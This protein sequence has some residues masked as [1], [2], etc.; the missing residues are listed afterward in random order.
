ETVNNQK[1]KSV[2]ANPGGK[3]LA[4]SG[5][6]ATNTV[7]AAANATA[8]GSNFTASAGD[9]TVL[10]TNSATLT[11]S[12]VNSSSTSLEKTVVTKTKPAPGGGTETYEAYDVGVTLAFNSIGWQPQNVL[13]NGLD[14][15]LGDTT[16]GD[17]FGAD[18]GSGATASLTNTV[19]DASGKVTVE[20][21][22]QT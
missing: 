10:A 18:V 14:A 6:I 20:A 21:Q 13:F 4:A 11:A 5:I 9:V 8:T 12:A 3:S 7:L 19:V 17:A 1:K 15:L 22:T 2:G 16:L